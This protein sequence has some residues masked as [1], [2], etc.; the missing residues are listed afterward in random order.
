MFKKRI[1]EILE[2]ILP[3][4]RILVSQGANFFGQEKLGIKQIRGNGVL[5]LTPNELFFEMFIPKKKLRISIKDITK[6]ESTKWHLKKTKSRPLL[7]VHF[8]NK[9]GKEDSAAWLVSD[10]NL[11]SQALEQRISKK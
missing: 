10:L 2:K 9:E 4:D 11:W 5:I 3:E 1:S 7:K 8:I 6:L